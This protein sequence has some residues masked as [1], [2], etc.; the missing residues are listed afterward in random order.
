MLNTENDFIKVKSYLTEKRGWYQVLLVYYINGHRKQKWKSLK[1][2]AKNGTKRKA[3]CK[4]DDITREF[5]NEL[6]SNEEKNDNNRNKTSNNRQ[7]ISPKMLFSNY[8]KDVWLPSLKGS[9]ELTTYSGYE[10]KVKIIADYFN[11]KEVKLCDLRKADIR[12][13]YTFLREK[14]GVN[15]T[16][17]N[18][19]HANIHKSLQDAINVFE[20]IEVNPAT[21]LRQKLKQNNINFYNEDELEKLYKVAHDAHS[22]IEL[23]ILIASH[24][25][26]RR[27]EVCGL[28]WHAINFDTH[29]ITIRHT[30]VQTKVNGQ[31]KIVKKD[32]TKNK[33]SNRTLPLIP[34][35]EKQLKKELKK[36]EENKKIFGNAYKN[37][38]DYVL[39]DSEGKLIKPNFVTKKF[40]ELIDKN[41][42]R[43]IKFK[44]LRH[45]CATLLIANGITLYKVQILLGHSTVKTTETY[46][47]N[48][49]VIDKQEAIDTIANVLDKKVAN[50]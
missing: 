39:V 18:L 41:N 25:G 34:F 16:T 26:L 4:K 5:E 8:I 19:Y 23:H 11:E 29:T 30:V 44:N 6:N 17:I 20:L 50:L 22:P 27:E 14:R 12:N 35:I 1:M 43:P 28:K 31:C 3:E 46:Y 24:Y 33:K 10:F 40:K 38:E 7:C 37:K 36:Q 15:N 42:L 9:I 48:T 2:E 21:G 13:F 47:A 49:E 32:R 45:S